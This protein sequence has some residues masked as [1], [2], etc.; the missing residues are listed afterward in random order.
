MCSENRMLVMGLA[1]YQGKVGEE[2]Q[3]NSDT[4]KPRSMISQPLALALCQQIQ[5]ENRTPFARW[6]CNRCIQQGQDGTP[7]RL[8]TTWSG[9]CE[10]DHVNQ[11][12]RSNA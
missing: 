2:H 12:Y 9:Y 3:Q 6:R 1:W 7:A 11:R 10:C 4:E 8:V 5:Q